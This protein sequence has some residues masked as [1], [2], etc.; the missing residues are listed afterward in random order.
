MV[1]VEIDDRPARLARMAERNQER[2]LDPID[3]HR[4]AGC[5]RPVRGRILW[6]SSSPSV[7][8]KQHRAA[9]TEKI[10]KTTKAQ[11]TF[12]V[13]RPLGRYGEFTG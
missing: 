13:E 11:G 6:R 1:H 9:R 7:R 12:S 3:L 8:R 5:S 4:Q 2:L 10:P